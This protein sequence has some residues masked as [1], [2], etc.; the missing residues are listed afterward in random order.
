M[1]NG[2]SLTPGEQRDWQAA[3]DAGL[4]TRCGSCGKTYAMT[5]EDHE[6]G[7]N[8]CEACAADLSGQALRHFA[9]DT[10]AGEAWFVAGDETQ[11][12]AEA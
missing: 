7:V 5:I 3:F 8:V 11:E 6:R 2:S 12:G 9:M 4:E 10:G 1:E